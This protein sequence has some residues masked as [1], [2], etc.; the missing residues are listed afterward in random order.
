MTPDWSGAILLKFARTQEVADPECA[1]VTCAPEHCDHP[2]TF[3]FKGSLWLVV[4]HPAVATMNDRL[5][6]L[7]S[8]TCAL[9]PT[10][11]AKT[12]AMVR[13]AVKIFGERVTDAN[14]EDWGDQDIRLYYS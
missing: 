9:A 11:P 2:P 10:T 8:I 4:A 6:K 5:S 3:G 7:S 12:I 14:G 1:G 13:T